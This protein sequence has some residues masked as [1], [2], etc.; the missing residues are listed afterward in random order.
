MSRTL[1]KNATIVDGSGQPSFNGD[2]LIQD[3]YIKEVDPHLEYEDAK[4]IDA[5]GRYLSP[6]FIDIHRH[7]DIQPFLNN[8][9]GSTLIKQGI[10]TIVNGNCGI[11]YAPLT[12]VSLANGKVQIDA[13]VMGDYTDAGVISFA[14]YQA[15]IA[16][17]E[18]PVNILS[19]PGL[20]T[21]QIAVCGYK[22]GRLSGSEIAKVQHLVQEALDAGAP[23]VS[24]GLMYLPEIYRDQDQIIEMLAPLASTGK[25]LTTHIR[26][27]GDSL[28]ASVKEV[29]EIAGAVGCPLQISHFK[30]GGKT[31]W[32]KQ[33]HKAIAL[34]E[35][36]QAKGQTIHVDFYPYDA[37]ATS[38]NT[39]IPPAFVQGDMNKALRKM[40][41]PE[42]V[43]ELADSLQKTYSDW[44][45]YALTVG[46]D[47][48]ILSGVTKPENRRYI[49][50][51][52]A[53]AA[54]RFADGNIPQLVSDL[55]SSENGVVGIISRS[56]SQDDI[57]TVARLP[58]S[59][60]ISDSI[61]GSPDH[62]H[63][64]LNG[65]FPK[66]LREY[67]YERQVLTIEEAIHKM[68]ALPAKVMG[69]EKHGLIKPGAI[70]DLNLFDLDTFKDKAT[71]VT[72]SLES[73]GRSLCMLA[74]KIVLQDDTILE[75][76]QGQLIRI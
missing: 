14:D 38:L 52:V 27:E 29:I 69:L 76:E 5:G 28:V 64:R 33:I 63:P 18:L 43:K 35:E 20:G 23:G 12:D 54:D 60:L 7:A 6:G 9:F 44:D 32:D 30:S 72:G 58:Y 1:I 61:Y 48:V 62:P 47:R 75:Q 4:I 70:A 41:T 66:F 53:D 40:E 49:G 57:D 73:E 19:M 50:L 24:I 8:D 67:V 11:S 55:M 45:N 22:D 42:G 68:T 21:I 31:N 39:M 17:S 74:G 25:V 59:L 56:M 46:W 3:Q 36:A 13:P 26:G 10:T 51:T 34:V 2:V 71:F 65:S 37:G 15:Q 16:A